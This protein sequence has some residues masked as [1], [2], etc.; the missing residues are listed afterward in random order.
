MS[1]NVTD[2]SVTVIGL[3]PMG[4]SMVTAFLAAGFD[5]TVWNRTAAKADAMVQLG[6]TRADTVAEALDANAVVVLSLTHYDAM[7]A[8]LGPAA[9]HLRGKIVA[10]LSSDSPA[11]ARSGAAWAVGHGA[12]FLSGGFMSQGD[13]ITHPLSYLFVSGPAPVFAATEELLTTL[14]P[15]EYL[16]AD[17]GLSQVFYQALLTL[18]H[19]M[20]LAF[21]QAMATIERSGQDI[22]RFTPYAQRAM[23]SFKDFIVSFTVAAKSG[24]W[25]EL[26]AL[27]MMDAGAQHV[28][29]ASEDVGVDATLAHAAQGLWRK[30]I[31]ASEAA[32][33]PVPTYRLIRDAAAEA[34]ATQAPTPTP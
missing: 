8:V 16:G 11:K 3:G 29:E 22:D 33:E 23:D 9:D 27:R 25:G 34:E 30:A 17:Y 5:V 28:I 6:A 13:D 19:P 18:F 21:E 32:G 31:A 15:L 14:S 12:Q 10:N 26:A 20:L 2:R 1:H 4:Q 7:Y 24:G